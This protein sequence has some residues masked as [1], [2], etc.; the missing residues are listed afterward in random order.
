MKPV[1]LCFLST[2][3]LALALMACG[4]KAEGTYS[5]ANGLA[6]L[7]LR[8][9]G[10]ASVTLMGQTQDCSYDVSGN[11][12]TVNCAGDKQAF[13]LND[14]GSLTGPGLIGV[15]KKSK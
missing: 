1:R 15:L 14:D 12:I 4:P 3:A 11:T 9:G 7:E 10:K 2:F 13:R 8:S 5:S 6:V